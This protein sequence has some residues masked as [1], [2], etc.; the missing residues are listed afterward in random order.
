MTWV[1]GVGCGV[2]P[3]QVLLVGDVDQ[4]PSVGPG[5][6]LEDIQRSG[7]VPTAVLTTVFR[8]VWDRQ[9]NCHELVESASRANTIE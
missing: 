5:T 9:S 7:V 8:Q 2:G 6:V 4:L 3:C 1:N